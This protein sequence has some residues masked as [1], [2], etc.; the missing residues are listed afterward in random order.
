MQK[1]EQ[2]KPTPPACGLF[3]AYELKAVIRYRSLLVR[4]EFLT[5]HC[6]SR[7]QDECGHASGP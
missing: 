6:F 3:V 4:K 5:L 7:G 1:K 2:K